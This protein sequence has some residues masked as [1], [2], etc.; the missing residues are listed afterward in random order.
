MKKIFLLLATLVISAAAMAQSIISIPVKQNPVFEVSTDHLD[1]VFADNTLDLVLGA[2]IV[3]TGGSGTYSYL[4]RDAQGNELGTEEQLHVSGPGLY[5]LDVTDTCDCLR[6][7]TFNVGTASIGEIADSPLSI[8]PNPSD[9]FIRINGFE[10]CSISAVS[11]AGQLVA[12]LTSESGMPITEADLSHLPSGIY[13]LT[14][15][16]RNGRSMISRLIIR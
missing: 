8:S 3:I 1:V 4:W 5:T 16:D 9:G 15:T 12:A 7:V 13:L 11:M 14:L 2:D 6:T 10:A